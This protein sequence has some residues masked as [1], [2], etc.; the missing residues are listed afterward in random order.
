MN[1]E[2]K[3]VPVREGLWTSDGKPQL[4][5]INAPSAERFFSR[6]GRMGCAPTAN[7]LI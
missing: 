4:I 2:K 5:G 3:R 1:E 7:L 6:K